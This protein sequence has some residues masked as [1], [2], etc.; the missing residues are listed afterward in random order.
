[1]VQ[2]FGSLVLLAGVLALGAAP[3]ALAIVQAK[4]SQTVQKPVS[5]ENPVRPGYSASYNLHSVSRG[6]GQPESNSG[7]Y[8]VRVLTTSTK[9]PKGTP[10]SVLHGKGELGYTDRGD[11]MVF[12]TFKADGTRMLHGYQGDGTSPQWLETVEADRGPHVKMGTQ[13]MAPEFLGLPGFPTH[14]PLTAK[15]V[16]LV[17]TVAGDFQALRCEALSTAPDKG[18]NMLLYHRVTV[19]YSNQVGFLKARVETEVHLDMMGSVMPAGMATINIEATHIALANGK[20]FGYGG[21]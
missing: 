11:F 9:S 13:F 18:R 2:R 12:H 14:L 8:T 4:K 16:E 15:S 5:V 17:T 10:T 7:T 19:W 20:T 21:R 3:E 6:Y 1:M